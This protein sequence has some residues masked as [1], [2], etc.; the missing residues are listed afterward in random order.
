MMIVNDSF[1][2]S[3]YKYAGS[4]AEVSPATPALFDDAPDREARVQVMD[5]L[6]D[7]LNRIVVETAKVQLKQYGPYEM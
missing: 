5:S 3:P 4:W 2:I 7:L 6:S 1:Q